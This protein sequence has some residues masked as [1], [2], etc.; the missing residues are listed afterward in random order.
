MVGCFND[1]FVKRNVG[2]EREEKMSIGTLI[3][4]RFNG[5]ET[6]QLTSAEMMHYQTEDGWSL[7]LHFETSLDCVK[8]TDD[9]LDYPSQPN[10]D[11]YIH[12][13]KFDLDRLVGQRFLVPH[14]YDDDYGDY[15]S[16]FYY[17]EHEE[18]D[19]NVV[20]F[21]AMQYG[22]Y[23]VRWTGT[24]IDPNDGSKPEALMEIDG[25]FEWMRKRYPSKA[26]G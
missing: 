7:S 13:T 9:T 21:I 14:G 26:E 8:T 18:L 16:R 25:H 10:G 22:R 12:K 6:Y 4:K 19:N 17:F 5:V 24:T 3:L 1:W 15:V 2:I 20:E 23:H 11:V